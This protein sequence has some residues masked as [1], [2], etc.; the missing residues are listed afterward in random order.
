MKQ[1]HNHRNPYSHRPMRHAYPNAADRAY[2]YERFLNGVTAVASCLG[3]L[4]VLFFL[5]TM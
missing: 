5:I 4:T 3:I 1:T 2:F